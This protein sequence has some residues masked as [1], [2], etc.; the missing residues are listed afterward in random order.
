MGT[1][2]HYALPVIIFSTSY[3]IVVT[4]LMSL[5]NVKSSTIPDTWVSNN[6][7]LSMYSNYWTN[8]LSLGLWNILLYAPIVI[9]ISYI[10]LALAT[11]DWA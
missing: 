8:T 7:I 9:S 6:A 1:S 2:D 4:L 10:A 11:P 3:L 5:I